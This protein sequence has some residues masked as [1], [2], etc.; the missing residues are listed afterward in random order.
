M[1]NVVERMS[2]VDA[3]TRHERQQFTQ[4]LVCAAFRLV[5]SDREV[6]SVHVLTPSRPTYDELVCYQEWARDHHVRLNVDGNCGMTV[7][8]ERDA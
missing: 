5:G 2:V 3:I 1:S 4:S 8:P 6:R 7:R